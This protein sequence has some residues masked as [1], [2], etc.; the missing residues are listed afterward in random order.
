MLTQPSGCFGSRRGDEMI[1][2]VWLDRMRSMSG[3]KKEQP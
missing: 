2:N 1:K 3:T